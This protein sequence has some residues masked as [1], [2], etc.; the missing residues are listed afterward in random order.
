MLSLGVDRRIA[1]LDEELD[2]DW[3]I[4][5]L[6]SKVNTLSLS[7]AEP[8]LVFFDGG[9]F[10]SMDLSKKHDGCYINEFWKGIPSYENF[11]LHPSIDGVVLF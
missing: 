8:G 6:G 5:L 2:I 9:G 1:I 4:S 7:N 10:R 3:R 11:H